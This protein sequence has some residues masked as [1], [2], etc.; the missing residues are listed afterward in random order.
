[1]LE[2]NTGQN[3]YCKKKPPDSNR[4]FKHISENIYRM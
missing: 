1:M 4:A 2:M 3:T